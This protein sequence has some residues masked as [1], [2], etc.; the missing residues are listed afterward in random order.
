MAEDTMI[1][2]PCTTQ[3]CEVNIQPAYV[4]QSQLQTAISFDQMPWLLPAL[5][6]LETLQISGT[7]Y[8]GIGDLTISQRTADHVR[9]LLSKI[10]VRH[11][12]VPA[13]VP[14]SGGGIGISFLQREKEV[15]FTVFPEET[16]IAYMLSNETDEVVK[17]GLLTIDRS[18]MINSS[19]RWLSLT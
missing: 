18:E 10:V 15:T 12:P 16:D 4:V 7:T 8:P 14:I 1:A 13:V 3:S 5:L 6:R 19:L 11:L 17:D 2:A 9:Q